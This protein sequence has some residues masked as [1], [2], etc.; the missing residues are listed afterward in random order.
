LAKVTIEIPELVAL[1]LQAL[2]SASG[3]S[4]EELA[5]EGIEALAG[6]HKTRRAIVKERGTAAKAAGATYSLADLGWLD[7]YAGQ[8]VDEV[9]SFEG[10]ENTYLIL[11]TIEEA[12]QKKLDVEG[13]LKMTG[14][15]LMVLSV[16]ALSREVNN[17]G[18]SQ[19]F[20][21]ASCRFAPRIVDD[22]VR[23][24]CAE[25]AD[26]TQQALDS[27]EIPK[28]IVPAIEAAMKT[29]NVTRDRTLSR[30]D[31]AFYDQTVL[32]ERLFAYVKTHQAGI[33]I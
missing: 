3:K 26:I 32:S 7:G 30:C 23:I 22:L 12:I 20:T 11:H 17:G 15:M 31:I 24:G 8:T 27:L 6:S 2:A 19:F 4:V 25:I 21:N 16:M 9:L 10:T 5:L 33:V 18:Y 1:R 29:E 13:R 28:L 14:I